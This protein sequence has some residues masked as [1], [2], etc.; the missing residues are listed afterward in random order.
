MDR[1]VLEDLVSAGRYGELHRSIDGTES[2]RGFV[3]GVGAHWA[4]IEKADSD[5]FINGFVAVRVEDIVDF[6]LPDHDFIERGLA[7]LGEERQDPP[8]IDLDTDEGLVR[9]LGEAFGLVAVFI[10]ADDPDVCFVGQPRVVT[11]DA[12]SLFEVT[13]SAEWEGELTEYAFEDVTRV[14]AGGRYER[15][16]SLVAGEP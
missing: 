2:L 8:A 13:P 15:A 10:E 12:L 16:L 4:L 3:V 14:D 6:E 7:A 5:I 11:R 1:Q 9:T